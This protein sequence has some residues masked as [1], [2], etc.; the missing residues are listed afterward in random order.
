MENLLEKM[1]HHSEAM[2]QVH[3]EIGPFIE[4]AAPILFWGET[5]SGMEFYAKAIHEASGRTGKFLTIPGFALDADTVKQQFLG[6]DNRQGWLEEADKGTI[7]IKRI[8]ETSP[9]VQ[10]ILLHLLGNRSVDGRLQFSRKGSTETLEVN[11]RF[12]FSMAHNFNMA[13]QSLMN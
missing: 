13:L 4:S 2:Q 12:I 7:F 3:R 11:V 6:I 8:S 10:Q 5:G 1:I 9:E